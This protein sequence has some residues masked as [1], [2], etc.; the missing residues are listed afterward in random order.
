MDN[1][2]DYACYAIH[3]LDGPDDGK[4]DRRRGYLQTN[5]LYFLNDQERNRSPKRGFGVN[6]ICVQVYVIGEETSRYLTFSIRN[7]RIEGM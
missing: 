4:Y 7:E 3:D 1:G 5:Y 6:D 2:F